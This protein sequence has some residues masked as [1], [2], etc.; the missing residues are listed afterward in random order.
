MQNRSAILKQMGIQ[1]WRTQDGVLKNDVLQA[2]TTDKTLTVLPDVEVH[3][4]HA[5][6]NNTESV[7]EIQ[8]AQIRAIEA[9]DEQTDTTISNLA[10]TPHVVDSAAIDVRE[11]STLDQNPL[12]ALDMQGLQ[13]WV[14]LSANCSSCNADNSLLG[15]GFAQADWMFVV[16]APNSREL[17]AQQFFAG[18]AG[19]LFEAM[20]SA[21]GMTRE[22][23]YV[24]SIFKCAP[25]DDLKLSPTCDD[26]LQ[27][28]IE[29][30]SPKVII[31]FGEFVAQSLIKAND[32]IDVLRQSEQRSVSSNTI[33][34]PTFSPAQMLD[35]ADLKAYVWQDLK[36]ALSYI[37]HKSP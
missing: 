37:S 8:I 11:R 12:S 24:S 34:I 4:N 31:A 20:L 2:E 7:S 10:D 18:R 21:L 29:L 36:K 17:Q 27:R 6:V 5:I 19:T 13:E 35:S 3:A 33:V 26:V 30:V 1:E 14:N 23:V 25:T 28:Q 32:S 16:D 9:N 15:Q 22:A